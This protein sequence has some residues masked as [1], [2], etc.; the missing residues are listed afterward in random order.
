[1]AEARDVL[2]VRNLQRLKHLP[3][4]E[5]FLDGSVTVQFE[6]FA[7]CCKSVNELL[8]KGLEAEG[9]HIVLR[10]LEHLLNEAERAVSLNEVPQ[11]RHGCR[12]NGLHLVV[13]L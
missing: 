10:V 6:N 1:M 11:R 7:D 5:S 9:G 13:V 2:P 8:F 4:V 3:D 12:V